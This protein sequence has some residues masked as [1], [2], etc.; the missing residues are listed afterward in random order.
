MGI[1]GSIHACC[2]ILFHCLA[3]IDRDGIGPL[4]RQTHTHLLE[5]CPKRVLAMTGSVLDRFDD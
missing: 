3:R 1:H 4:I 5:S 2:E